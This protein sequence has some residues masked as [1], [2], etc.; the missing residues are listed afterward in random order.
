MAY[1]IFISQAAVDAELA[2]ELRDAL[3]QCLEALDPSADVFLSTDVSAIEFGSNWF[4]KTIDALQTSRLC[5]VLLT[6][7]SIAKPWVMF[8]AGGA[9]NLLPDGNVICLCAKGITRDLVPAPL[10]STQLVHLDDHGQ[11]EGLMQS[12]SDRLGIGASISE[13]AIAELCAKASDPVG[14]WHV[15]ETAS[16]AIRSGDS[17]YRYRA[18]FQRAEKRVFIASQNL[19]SLIKSKE[20]EERI[21]DF[22]RAEQ[23]RQLDILICDIS[24]PEAVEAWSNINPQN[25]RIEFT[26][27]HHLT[28]ATHKFKS[29][30]DS[31]RAKNIGDITVKVCPLF[32]LTISI[33][34]PDSESA[35]LILQPVVNF[36]MKSEERP[37]VLLPR[38][39]S[40]TAFNYYLDKMEE[41]YNYARVIASTID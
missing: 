2:N 26:Y 3:S 32:P 37:H 29:L 9:Y 17:P 13:E 41:T 4:D 11:V 25:D 10:N 6:P 24:H 27:R 7:R 20:D 14:G 35:V 18:L 28:Q 5:L 16:M 30:V 12:L 22:L 21:L 31:A 36:G 34:D 33:V 39:E 15:V 8:E 40:P 19:Y 38:Q 1:Q 23:G